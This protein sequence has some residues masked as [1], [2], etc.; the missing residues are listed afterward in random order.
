[1]TNN[2]LFHTYL[3]D[4]VPVEYFKDGETKGLTVKIL[5]SDDI[6]NNIFCVVNQFVVKENNQEKR[7]DVVIFIN[8]LPLVLVELKSALDEQATL[9]K[10]YIQI[11]N[12]KT[13]IP[14]IFFYNALCVISD[15]IDARVSSLSAPFSRYLAWK[16]PEK[17]EN[18]TFPEMQ[19]MTERMFEKKT[20]INLIRHNTVFESEEKMDAK[21]GIKSIVKIKKVAAYHQYYAVQKAVQKTLEATH[22]SEGDRK[23]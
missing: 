5:D 9:E 7:C 13:A 14:N 19:I 15:G 22:E 12:Y 16:S 20:L 2:E 10:A 4:G 18:E 8:G 1:M 6:E 3:T 23:I 21:T 11:Q 17:S